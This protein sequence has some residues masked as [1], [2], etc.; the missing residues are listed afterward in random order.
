MIKTQEAFKQWYFKPI[1][2]TNPEDANV[3]NELGVEGKYL[4]ANLD[5]TTVDFMAS[6]PIFK[7]SAE[8]WLLQLERYRYED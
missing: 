3:W 4:K 8:T 1:R 7:L 2:T 6:R 5:T